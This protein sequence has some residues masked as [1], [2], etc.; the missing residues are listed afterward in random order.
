M[1]LKQKGTGAGVY[2][3]ET[4]KKFNSSLGRYTTAFQAQV[5]AINACAVENID[6]NYRNRNI[7]ILSDS[8]VASKA[9]GKYEITLNW[10]GTA[11]K[12][13]CNWPD[14]TEFN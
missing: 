14:I 11:N 2:C 1:V 13:S 6:K 7:Y 8:Q 4:R 9:L 10:S 3:H 12:P 5:Y